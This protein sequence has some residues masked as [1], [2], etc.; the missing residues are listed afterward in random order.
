MTRADSSLEFL[1]LF[2]SDFFARNFKYFYIITEYLKKTHWQKMSGGI[3]FYN[4]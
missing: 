2:P 4:D 1:K 3:L